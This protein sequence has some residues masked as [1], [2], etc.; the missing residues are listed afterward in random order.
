[1]FDVARFVAEC[2]A[3]MAAK[4]GRRGVCELLKAA[5][6]DPAGIIATLG[7]PRRA[8]VQELHRS[9]RFT[10]LHIVW[11]PS[12]TQTPHNHLL[13][14]EV[15]VYWGR[16]D[17]ILW[18]RSSDSKWPIEATG[19]AS[20]PAGSCLSLKSDAIHSVTNP[21]DTVTAGLHVYGGDLFPA[22][23][24]SMWHGET[25]VEAPLGYERDDRAVDIYNARL[26]D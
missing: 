18:R 9:P 8:G 6:L 4:R 5:I 25:L 13:W 23:P 7:K 11:P 17:N 21:L 24:R 3:A 26:T 12:F 19:V 1:M 10:I 14:A 22:A 15:G 16:E 20:L 2:E